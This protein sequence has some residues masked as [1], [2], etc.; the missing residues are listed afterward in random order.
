VVGAA[1]LLEKTEKSHGG[2]QVTVGIEKVMHDSAVYGQI[3]SAW[4][5]NFLIRPH[6]QKRSRG[7][8][9]EKV[10]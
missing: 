1:H 5:Q 2:G 10:Q 3:L 6:T 8:L 9:E 7:E 4:P